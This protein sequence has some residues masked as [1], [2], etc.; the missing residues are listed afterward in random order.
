[1]YCETCFPGPQ[2]GTVKMYGC[3]DP[4][5]TGKP[6]FAKHVL[7]EKNTHWASFQ[8]PRAS[9]RLAARRAANEEED[10]ESGGNRPRGGNA[11][12]RL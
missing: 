6:C 7:G 11:R 4:A 12:R 10:E 8:G 3:C 5:K 9:P 1:M 2:D